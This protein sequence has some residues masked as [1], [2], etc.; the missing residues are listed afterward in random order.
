MVAYTRNTHWYLFATLGKL[1]V[2]P[3]IISTKSLQCQI[4]DTFVSGGVEEF[5]LPINLDDVYKHIS[6]QLISKHIGVSSDD[7]T[8]L[9]DDKTAIDTNILIRLGSATNI[10]VCGNRNEKEATFPHQ[11]VAWKDWPRRMCSKGSIIDGTSSAVW[12]TKSHA[13]FATKFHWR[14]FSSISITL[15]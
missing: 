8:L 12:T 14:V 11:T 6:Q 9:V 2:P 7:L 5:L 15:K 3:L 13:L 1:R 10:Y 4:T